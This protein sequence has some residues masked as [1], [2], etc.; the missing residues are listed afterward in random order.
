MVCEKDGDRQPTD[1]HGPNLY[2]YMS[3]HTYVA[4][5]KHIKITFKHHHACGRQ[6]N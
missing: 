6:T 4:I 5:D 1:F 3:I 2:V